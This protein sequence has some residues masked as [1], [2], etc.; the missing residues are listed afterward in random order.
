VNP[1]LP[2]RQQAL[3]RRRRAVD[4]MG[5]GPLWIARAIEPAST[6]LADDRPA[7]IAAMDLDE[8]AD[9]VKTCRACALGAT[10][11]HAV[12]GEGVGQPHWLVVGAAPSRDDD[13]A[14]APLTGQ[15]GRLLDA[16]LAAVDL[17]RQ[18][19]VF[20]TTAVKC[21][22]PDDRA[23]LPVEVETCRPYLDRQVALLGPRL[24]LAIG[25]PTVMDLA[26][27]SRLDVP[28]VATHDPARLLAE[29]HLKAEAWADLCRARSG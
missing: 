23:P 28:L 16:M 25:D 6:L 18:T 4:A 10:R 7:A 22:P 24:L 15:P 1:A 3:D 12:F 14:G 11:A 9:A 2:D 26:P 5:L 29:P 8:L 17:S 21:R 20:V 27:P 19:N 13:L